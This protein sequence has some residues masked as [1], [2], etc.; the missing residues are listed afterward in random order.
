M[1]LE[2]YVAI[3]KYEVEFYVMKGVKAFYA[4]KK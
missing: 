1:F 3:K 4:T 2:S